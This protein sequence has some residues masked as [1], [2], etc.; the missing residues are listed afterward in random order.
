MAHLSC[1]PGEGSG[2]VR[3]HYAMCGAGGASNMGLGGDGALRRE[4]GFVFRRFLKRGGTNF[5][6]EGYVP[7]KGT[8][9]GGGFKYFL[10]SPRKFG[11]I[12]ILTNIFKWVEIT[13]Q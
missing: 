11:T 13:N 7:S 10:F 5:C 9:L 6:L 12:L 1:G 8:N 4:G 2:E 3:S